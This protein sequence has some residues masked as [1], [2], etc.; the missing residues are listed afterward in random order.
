M[1]ERLFRKEALDRLS[2]PEELDQLMQITSPRSWLALLA[3]ILL[4]VAGI[5]WGIWGSIAETT[6]GEGIL[7]R[8]GIDTISAPVSGRLDDIYIRLGDSVEQG[9]VIARVLPTNSDELVRVESNSNGRVIEVR[10]A[11]G[12][13]VQIGEPLVNLEPTGDVVQDIEAIL[14]LP[15]TEGKKVRPGMKVQVIPTTVRAEETGVM[16]GWVRTVSEFPESQESLRRVLENDDL[17][18]RFFEITNNAPIQ[19][20]VDLVPARDSVSGYKWSSPEGAKVDIQSGTLFDATI[21]LDE[22]PPIELIFPFLA[23]N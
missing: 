15:A 18:T 4:I 23:R 12:N 3:I 1:Q 13:F 6:S 17:V 16:L 2:S 11:A 7:I 22:K 20:R 21:I 19:V 9:Q 14:F 8:G 5:A 10:V